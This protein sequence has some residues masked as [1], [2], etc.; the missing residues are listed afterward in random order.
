MPFKLLIHKFQARSL[1][2]N[3]IKLHRPTASFIYFASNHCQTLRKSCLAILQSVVQCLRVSLRQI[4]ILCNFLIVCASEAFAC[5]LTSINKNV[6]STINSAL[7]PVNKGGVWLLQF[8]LPYQIKGMQ[9]IWIT[10]GCKYFTFFF[11]FFSAPTAPL[12]PQI[13]Q[14]CNGD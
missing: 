1:T 12:R 4:S 3:V 13:M 2:R 7:P 10:W 9:I 14:S 6:H 5:N 8:S 11:L